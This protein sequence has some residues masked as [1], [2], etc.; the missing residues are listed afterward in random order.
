MVSFCSTKMCAGKSRFHLKGTKWVKKK[1]NYVHLCNITTTP[2]LP[3]LQQRPS[4]V[5]HE[6]L[7]ASA[8]LKLWPLNSEEW[9][10]CR[11]LSA[12]VCIFCSE[13]YYTV[14]FNILILFKCCR[15][16]FSLLSAVSGLLCGGY[17]LCRDSRMGVT[18]R[19]SQYLQ[20]GWVNMF[21]TEI[22]LESR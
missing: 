22:K 19:E 20:A 7:A 5:G 6:K 9:Y 1:L 16:A 8:E 17:L 12:A 3:G 4:K 2:P 13:A 14:Y 18:W 15:D 21:R 10:H 11:I